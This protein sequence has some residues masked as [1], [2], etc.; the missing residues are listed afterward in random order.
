MKKIVWNAS[1][2]L[3]RATFI[4]IIGHTDDKGDDNDNMVLSKLR[5]ASVRDY[6]I[7]EGIDASK[8]ITTG[9]GE[10]MPIASNDT[11]EGRAQN[12]RVE[13]RVLGRIQ[14]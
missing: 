6:L 11:K 14:E 10:T 9:M 12:R 7:S 2:L 5:A 13:I 1:G 3:S 8:M 4:E